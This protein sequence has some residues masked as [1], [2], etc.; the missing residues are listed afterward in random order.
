MSLTPQQPINNVVRGAVQ[1]L[2]MGMAGVRGL[3]I[4]TFDEPFRTPSHTA[5]L[6]AMR[7]QQVITEETGVGRVSDPLGGSW[8]V[9]HLTDEL[10]QRI[11][12]EV[13]RIEAAG[14]VAE[15]VDGGFFR[16]IFAETMDR[17]ARQVLE[18]ERR[19]V[20][21]NCH[22]AIGEEDTLL[23]DIAEARFE[24][25]HQ[26]ADRI[27]RWRAERDPAPVEGA[28]A[29]LRAAAD[30]RSADLMA[31]IVAGFEA[32]ATIGEMAAVLRESYGY[33]GD[34]FA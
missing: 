10:E 19:I 28:L 6:V 30:D 9:E 18:G 23:R 15:L 3:E 33:R 21:V 13:R 25:D 26:H 24:A 32:D 7:T 14:D 34:P 20:G 22:H 1:A 12:A 16:G 4:S 2:A 27:A 17:H 29:A 5:H 8:Y 11:D 31:P